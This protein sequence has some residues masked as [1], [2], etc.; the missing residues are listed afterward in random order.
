ML[1]VKPPRGMDHAE[2][3]YLDSR[4]SG[5]Y[6]TVFK[7][8]ADIE[9]LRASSGL[10]S[11][12]TPAWA[13]VKH[14]R[15]G[16]GAA[17]GIAAESLALVLYYLASEE[18]LSGDEVEKYRAAA[19]YT[20]SWLHDDN[21]DGSNETWHAD[22]VDGEEDWQGNPATAPVVHNAVRVAYDLEVSRRA[23]GTS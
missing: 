17:W 3:L 11:P 6:R 14:F 9:R 20:H 2:C 10:S 18:H 21:F 7:S 16:P 22:P 12:S 19:Q 5:L 15:Q 8:M 1:P 23:G 13:T 4:L